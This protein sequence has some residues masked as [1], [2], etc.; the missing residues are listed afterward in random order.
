M[1]S[2][3]IPKNMTKWEGYLLYLL[4]FDLFKEKIFIRMDWLIHTY[5][6]CWSE[7]FAITTVK[8]DIILM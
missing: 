8:V 6:S 3:K 5:L 1:D 2:T 7:S 4:L